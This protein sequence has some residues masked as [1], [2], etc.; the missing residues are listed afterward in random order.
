MNNNYAPMMY[1]PNMNTHILAKG[2]F[3]GDRGVYEWYVINYGSHPS[4]YITVPLSSRFFNKLENDDIVRNINCHGGMTFAG[5][6]FP[7]SVEN[8][9]YRV[10][11]WV[12]GWDYIHDTDYRISPLYTHEGKMW[13]TEEMVDECSNVIDQI[14]KI[15]NGRN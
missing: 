3:Q 4:C 13:S 12:L 5:E 1:S 10:N 15:D 11:G 8:I 14:I 9:A 2:A 7:I 6:Q